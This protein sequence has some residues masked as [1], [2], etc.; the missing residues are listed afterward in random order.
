MVGEASTTRREETDAAARTTAAPSMGAGVLT[1]QRRCPS[2][3][4]GFNVWSRKAS[5]LSDFGRRKPAE[6]RQGEGRLGLG[7][8]ALSEGNGSCGASAQMTA[9]T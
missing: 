7:Q 4:T 6:C 9:S 1:L 5:S 3:Q 2:Q 8:E